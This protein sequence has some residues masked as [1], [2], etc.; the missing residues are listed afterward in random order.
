VGSGPPG[1][2]DAAPSL[3]LL[4]YKPTTAVPD[5]AGRGQLLAAAVAP[6]ATADQPAGVASAADDDELPAVATADQPAG[7]ASAADDDEL[8]AVAAE[9]RI[10]GSDSDQGP[11]FVTGGP[12]PSPRDS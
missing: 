9:L 2:A 5:S 1:F 11:E 4:S 3:E 7:V 10:S 12:E 8:P 6:V